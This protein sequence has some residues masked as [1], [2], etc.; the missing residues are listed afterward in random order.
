M[1]VVPAVE[2][3]VHALGR[4]VEADLADAG[5]RQAEA[6]I[7][8]RLARAGDTAIGDL[9]RSF[10]HRRSTL[11]AILDRL[12]TR[13]LVRRRPHAT[14]RR[15]VVVALTGPGRTAARRAATAVERIETGIAARVTPAQLEGFHAVLDAIEQETT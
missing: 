3:A 7:L 9:H 8:A 14:D 13:G 10:G 5:L 1:E 12:E 6:H 15:S 4:A 11:T 2:R